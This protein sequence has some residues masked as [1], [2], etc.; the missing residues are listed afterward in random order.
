MIIVVLWRWRRS[1]E[2]ARGAQ[3]T[4]EQSTETGA[5]FDGWWQTAPALGLVH[6]IKQCLVNN[7]RPRRVVVAAHAH[8]ISINKIM[9]SVCTSGKTKTRSSLSPPPPLP[10]V[11]SKKHSPCHTHAHSGGPGDNND[12]N[13]GDDGRAAAAAARRSVVLTTRCT[14][15]N[16]YN[17]VRRSAPG[18]GPAAQAFRYCRR[19]GSVLT[20][21]HIALNAPPPRHCN[22][23]HDHG[24][25]RTSCRERTPHQQPFS[26]PLSTQ[27]DDLDDNRYSSL[28]LWEHNTLFS[29]CVVHEDSGSTLR[30]SLLFYR[31]FP[32]SAV[33]DGESCG[34]K[35]WAL[36]LLLFITHNNRCIW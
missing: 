23:R 7:C 14:H 11:A 8:R 1:N 22:R 18:E 35:Q 20:G 3:T 30:T 32:F 33:V 36:L 19:R 15:Y 21:A 25:W 13:T 26:R 29:F 24:Q 4:A 34:V 28:T 12:I 10:K 31:V 16:K 2:D 5:R 17:N 27:Y 6:V 9:F